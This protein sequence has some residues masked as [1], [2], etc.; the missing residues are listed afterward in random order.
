MRNIPDLGT[1]DIQLSP[2]PTDGLLLLFF[3]F[4]SFL[5]L[6]EN[7]LNFILTAT[8]AHYRLTTVLLSSRHITYHCVSFR[9]DCKRATQP[10]LTATTLL[11]I[12]CACMISACACNCASLTSSLGSRPSPRAFTLRANCAW[13]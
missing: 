8:H 10:I 4:V 7:K 9:V 5:S 11:S 1:P 13:E 2:P 6:C 12:G 3:I